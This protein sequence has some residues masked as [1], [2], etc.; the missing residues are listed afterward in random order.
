VQPQQRLSV[1][2]CHIRSDLALSLHCLVLRHG[3]CM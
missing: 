3:V 2:H 1:V